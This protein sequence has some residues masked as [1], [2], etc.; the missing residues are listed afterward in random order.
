[1]GVAMK[2]STWDALGNT[3]TVIQIVLFAFGLPTL[4]W[5]LGDWL[6]QIPQVYL[7]IT[8]S[9]CFIG[10]IWSRR[11]WGEM[12]NVDGVNLRFIPAWICICIFLFLFSLW[13][14]S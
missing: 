9:A 13:K 8:L 6:W 12:R 14:H 2:T 11:Q 10:L 3:A 7:G 1:M 5:F 4:A